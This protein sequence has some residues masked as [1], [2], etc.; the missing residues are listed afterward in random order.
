MLIALLITLLRI[1]RGVTIPG[2]LL[3]IPILAFPMNCC[4]NAQQSP[5]NIPQLDATPA[6]QQGFTRFEATPEKA[7][8][9]LSDDIEETSG[10]I[11]FRGAWWTHNDSGGKPEVYRL[12]TSDGSIEQTITLEG[13]KNHDWEDIATDGTWLY[14]G[15]F[16]NNGGRRTNL[17]VYKIAWSKVPEQGDV[18]VRPDVIRFVWADQTNLH[19]E[20]YKHNFDCEAMFCAK[21]S[22]WL[23]SKDWADKNSRLYRLPVSEGIYKISPV[24]EFNS[25]LL[26]TGAD[27][28]TTSKT[29]VL[30]GYL[31]YI[32]AIWLMPDFDPEKPAEGGRL[33]IDM[34]SM[35]GAQTEGICFGPNGILWFSAEK[36]KVHPQMIYELNVNT[37][38][39][40]M[41]KQQP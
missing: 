33:R 1:R 24:Y 39:R 34:T 23:F 7:V 32:P 10:L 3:L 28:D 18:S 13:V 14:I 30:I 4:V 21:G 27:Y 16:G 41:L 8:K 36:T 31:D 26:V 40:P 6:V 9:S 5:S 29:L 22:L 19:S 35:A 38:I 20:A 2:A 25:N 17:A 11:W 12:N 37:F 15:D